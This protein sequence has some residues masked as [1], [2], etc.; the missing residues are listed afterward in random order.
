LLTYISW[1]DTDKERLQTFICKR[2]NVLIDSLQSAELS[3]LAF[4]AGTGPKNDLMSV[5]FRYLLTSSS[6][7]IQSTVLRML[8]TLAESSSEGL[9]SAAFHQLQQLPTE[10]FSKRLW[11]FASHLLTELCHFPFILLFSG[12]LG[13]ETT[14]IDRLDERL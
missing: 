4:S 6:I 14:E 12:S 7:E 13:T 2:F 5:A 1:L 3:V 8:I 9:R 10:T 11:T